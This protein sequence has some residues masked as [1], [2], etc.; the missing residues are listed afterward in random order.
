LQAIADAEQAKL[1]ELMVITSAESVPR[2]SRIAELMEEQKKANRRVSAARGRL[3]RARKDG[4]AEK[5][6]A[7][8]RQLREL[9]GEAWR[10]GDEAIRQ[11]QEMMSGGLANTGAVLD[12]MGRAWEAQA[13]VTE[14]HRDPD[15]GQAGS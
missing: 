5:I 14:T 6:G 4:S 15:P 12:Q 3:T 7:A 9:E 2:T 1:N 11:S 8:A 13:A 10:I